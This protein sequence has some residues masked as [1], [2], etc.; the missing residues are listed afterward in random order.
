M[1]LSALPTRVVLRWDLAVRILLA[2][3]LPSAVAV[4]GGEG[5]A[6]PSLI[7]AL[8]A[9]LVSLSCLGP[10]VRRPAWVAVAAVGTPVA[11]SL[12]IVL[13]TSNTRGILV[14]FLLYLVQGALTEAGLI[15]QFAWFPVATAGLLATVL[16]TE[17]DGVAT[18]FL[19]ACAGA[20][21]AALLIAVVPLVL[22]P[23]R[24]PL[25]PAA[26]QVDTARLR[27]MVTRPTLH[28]WVFPLLLGGLASVVLVAVDAMTGGFRPFW[29]VFALVGVLAPTAGKARSFTWQTVVSTLGGILVAAVML[30]SGLALGP[31]L[32]L[33]LL[34]AIVGAA[35]LLRHGIIAKLL[36]TPLPVLV[37]A[38]AIGPG[39]SVALGYRL[40]EY[41]FGA[42]VGFVA[43]LGGEWLT[44]RLETDRPEA[45]SDLAG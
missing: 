28:D 8:V 18:I 1:D 19:A 41:L 2:V 25:P 31:R 38:A 6:G 7:A 40:V 23:P 16:T 4:W 20:A 34:M 37:A 29:A 44:Q 5:S 17:A 45:Q 21:W 9:A 36:L 42:G 14:V 35:F 33:A 3:A 26:L 10:E 13:G 15:S 30:A 12:G 11:I 39:G 22:R 24:I 43:A 32:L 27:R